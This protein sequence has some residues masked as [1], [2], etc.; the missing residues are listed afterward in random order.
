MADLQLEVPEQMEDRRNR[1]LLACGRFGA[2]QEHQVEIAERSH[3]AAAGAA[4]ADDCYGLGEG[5]G[6]H[7]IVGETHQLVVEVGRRS[8]RSSSAVGIGGE[9]TGHLRPPLVQRAAQQLRRKSVAVGPSRKR[10]E[11]VG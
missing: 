2:G 1:C 8:R 5:A 9:P 6:C 10:G 3:F 11:R 4:E 7:E